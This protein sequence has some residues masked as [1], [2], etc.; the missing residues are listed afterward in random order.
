MAAAAS[1]AV[2]SADGGGH[3]PAAV[4][5][6]GLDPLR[7]AAGPALR[8][9][10]LPPGAVP[11]PGAV[12]YGL[13]LLRRRGHRRFLLHHDRWGGGAADLHGAGH[14]GRGGAVLL[15]PLPAPASPLGLLAG[16][17]GGP[18]GPIDLAFPRIPAYR[19][20]IFP[21]WQK[22]LSPG[23]KTVYTMEQEVACGLFSERRRGPSSESTQKSIQKRAKDRP[24]SSPAS[25]F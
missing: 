10:P 21:R 22:S 19:K 24:V 25:S 12:G 15:P 23:R 11:G 2:S 4:R 16:L 3:L 17:P 6:P 8:S 5:L 7:G 13:S 9:A 18:A 1:C 14:P 20:K